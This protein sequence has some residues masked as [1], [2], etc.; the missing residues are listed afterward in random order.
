MSDQKPLAPATGS[1]EW[2]CNKCGIVVRREYGWRTWVKSFCALKG[3]DAR[4][5]RISAPNPELSHGDEGGAK[6]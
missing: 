3:K 4:L 1:A 5:Y 2:R 6:S